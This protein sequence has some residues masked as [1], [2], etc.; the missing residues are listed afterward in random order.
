MRIIAVGEILW[1][2]FD[3]EECL[4]GAALNFSATSQRLGNS[5]VLLSAV[6]SDVRGDRAIQLMSGLGIQS[7]HLQISPDRE[8]GTAVV[9]IDPQGNATYRI[10]RPA[11]FD[12]YPLTE[13]TLEALD[14]W[15]PEWI[16]FGTLA[17]TDTQNEQN[18]HRLVDR[19]PG[20]RCFY[21]INLREGHWDL[22]LVRRLSSLATIVK[23]NESE[24]ETLFQLTCLDEAYTLELFCRHWS[25]A[26][27]V[28]MI[29]VTLGGKGCAIYTGDQLSQFSG[30][31]VD[32]VDTVGAGDAFAASYLHGCNLGWPVAQTA[33]FAN[34][35][36]AL[37]ASR[38]G[39]N[40]DWSFEECLQLASSRE[41]SHA[42]WPS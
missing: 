14:A 29:C 20:L 3:K 4:G 1:D 21:D 30:F 33:S 40:P 15:K 7:E 41:A 12:Q 28:Q 37:V 38:A 17:Q 2:V 23:L 25:S 32:V 13:Q 39:A 16:Y 9:V 42:R 27:R 19:F 8:T 5:V 11:A 24:A 6:G 22:E 26:H 18:L 35:M 10:D 36:G 34:A 31:P